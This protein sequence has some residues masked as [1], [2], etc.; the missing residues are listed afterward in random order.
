MSGLLLY[1]PLF[2]IFHQFSNLEIQETKFE[3]L[4]IERQINVLAEKLNDKKMNKKDTNTEID[5]PISCK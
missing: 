1:K 5:S 3:P 4:E 2:K